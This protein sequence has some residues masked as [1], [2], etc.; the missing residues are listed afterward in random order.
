MGLYFLH[1][2]LASIYDAFS[3]LRFSVFSRKL[4]ASDRKIL[5][6][7]F[8][9]YGRMNLKFK[10]EF[11][12]KLERILSSKEFVGRGGIEIVTEEMEI[13]I[14]ATITMVVFGW[15]GVQLPHFSRILIYPN[16]YYSTVT[17]MY[18]RGEVNPKFG[19]IVVSWR[20]FLE[21]LVDESDGI[22]LGIHEIAHALKLENVISRNEEY[23]FL[24]P[25]LKRQYREHMERELKLMKEG[26]PSPFRQ[27]ALINEDEF[28]AV[29]LEYFFEK[30]QS[31][32][33]ERP[34]FYHT[35]VML[36]RQDPLVV[37]PPQSSVKVG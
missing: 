4:T 29:I 24:D 26:K 3:E 32:Q 35:L 10:K 11:E 37:S 6:D 5:E 22:N 27:N 13:L 21:G 17:K 14:G 25:N 20:C 1:E 12:R 19:L 18:H 34:E 15:K 36:L 23:N 33:A 28:F 2:L 16:T 7:H 9:Y 31:F 30:P 8:P